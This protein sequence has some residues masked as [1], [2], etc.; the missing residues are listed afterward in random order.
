MT[1]YIQQLQSDHT[2]LSLILKDRR[3]SFND[4]DDQHLQKPSIQLLHQAYILI[5]EDALKVLSSLIEYF[6][7]K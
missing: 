1:H 3:E 6:S 7:G 5:L 2:A 4:I